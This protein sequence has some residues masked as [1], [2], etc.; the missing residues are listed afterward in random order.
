M[1]R[2]WREDYS[3]QRV[4]EVIDDYIHNA[5]DREIILANLVDG[6]SY[7]E[8]AGQYSLAYESIKDIMRKGR[9]ALDR[10]YDRIL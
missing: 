1:K 8:L 5:R 9:A 2:P 4:C 10:H 6:V 7:D 3:N